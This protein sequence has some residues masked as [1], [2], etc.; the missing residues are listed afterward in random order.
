MHRFTLD[1]LD[2]LIDKQEL[3]KIEHEATNIFQ[4]MLL[5]VRLDGG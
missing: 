5:Q 1:Q 4:A 3:V 2:S